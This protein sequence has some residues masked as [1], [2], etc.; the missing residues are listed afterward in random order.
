MI[1]FNI[2]ELIVFIIVLLLIL[3]I[4]L[5]KYI[6]KWMTNM[7]HKNRLEKNRDLAIRI[8]D[9]FEDLLCNYKIKIPSEDY[10]QGEDEACIYGTQYYDLEQSIIG[11]LNERK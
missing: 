1:I 4:Y 6:K 9:E 11:I 10:E 5:V 3:I 2:T 8:I 7:K